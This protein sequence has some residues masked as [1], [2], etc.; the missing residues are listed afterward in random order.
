MFKNK[1]TV[2]SLLI[3]IIAGALYFLSK[4]SEEKQ[5]DRFYTFINP[6]NIKLIKIEKGGKAFKLFSRDNRWFVTDNSSLELAVDTSRVLPVFEFINDPGIIQK[7]TKKESFYPKFEL[8]EDKATKVTLQQ[9][10]GDDLVFYVGKDKDYS[11]RFVRKKG[12]PYVYLISKRINLDMDKDSWIYKKIPDYD[13]TKLDYIEYDCSR[14]NK[15]VKV[16]Y[17]KSGDKLFMKDLPEN[18][19]GKD[20]YR[21]R[22]DFLKISVSKFVPR[23]EK[24][25]TEHVVSHKLFFKT[26]ETVTLSFLKSTGEKSNKHYLDINVSAGGAVQDKDLI[27]LKSVSDRYLFALSWFDKKKYLIDCE[28]F[29]EDKPEKEAPEIKVRKP[30]DQ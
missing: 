29:F 27:Y 28:D 17:D 26:G 12:D 24:T 5:S 7:I 14:N 21:L 11:S 22:D 1:V 2:F 25:E 6:E 4:N 19:Q 15:T 23:S 13:F 20:L 18:K 3:I 16:Y 10:K 8:T 30:Q 9:R